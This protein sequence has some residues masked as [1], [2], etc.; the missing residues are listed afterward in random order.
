MM[1][2]TI[3]GTLLIAAFSLVSPAHW[4]GPQKD[5]P[6]EF[7][8]IVAQGEWGPG[9]PDV[10]FTVLEA[11][12][13]QL[14]SF[15]NDPKCWPDGTPKDGHIY[16]INGEPELVP[17]STAPCGIKPPNSLYSYARFDVQAGDIIT[18]D[19]R[20]D[21]GRLTI[22][23]STKAA[24]LATLGDKVWFDYNKNGIQDQDEEGV[25][26][27]QVDLYTEAGVFVKSDVTDADGLYL[28]T[29]LEPGA[30]Y[31]EFATPQG[32]SFT[33]YNVNN[34]TE[35]AAD[36]D[37]LVPQ[38]AISVSDQGMDGMAGEPL[39]YT[40]FYTN[41]DVSLPAVNVVVS[42]TIPAAARFSAAGSTPAWN[43][44]SIE[45]GGICR[46]TLPTLAV[47]TSGSATFVV[48]LDEDS[49]KVP[50]FLDLW[51]SLTQGSV[52]RTGVVTL[53]EGEVDLTVDAGIVE[54]GATLQTGTV[55]VPT[56][57]PIL[58]QPNARGFIYL[59]SIQ[60]KE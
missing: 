38:V 7:G 35:D 4:I 2:T 29:E 42:A 3:I 19:T 6:P 31:V 26:G 22:R 47:N 15:D 56:G 46:F 51:I 32:Y 18:G 20:H 39:T 8:K 11:G 1:L 5:V 16:Y 53:E 28:F 55:I 25:A 48:L 50:S 52:A 27:V 41:S 59:P 44:A 54:I 36:S 49:K 21:S 45:A 34:N 12:I 13:V 57:L 58:P 30:Y 10:H 23:F 17:A 14:E 24:L 60:S 43:C 33:K 40:V 37:P 9:S